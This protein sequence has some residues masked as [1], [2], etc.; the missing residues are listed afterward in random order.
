MRGAFCC[1]LLLLSSPAA[2]GLADEPDD[3][4]RQALYLAASLK[5]G[6]NVRISFYGQLR[7]GLQPVEG[8]GDRGV[9]HPQM[10]DDLTQ[11]VPVRER[12]EDRHHA[13]H[14]RGSGMRASAAA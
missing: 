13:G 2:A 6:T 12:L 14:F 4:L 8:F 7:R 1:G 11:A 9:R 10:L 3:L 5:D